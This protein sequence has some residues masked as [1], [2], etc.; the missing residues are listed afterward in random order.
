M[1]IK[2]SIFKRIISGKEYY[3]YQYLEDGKQVSKTISKLEAYDIA[4]SL[5]FKGRDVDEFKSHNFNLQVQYG[6][7]LISMTKVYDLYKRRYCYQDVSKYINSERTGGKV[8]ILYG[9][10]RTGKTTLIFQSISD[11][12][13]KD[14]AK[15][16]YIKCENGKTMYQLFEDL[17]YLTMNGF[18]Y[19]YIDEVTLLE[20]FISLSSTLSDIYA[21]K[22]KVILS[23]TDSLGFLIA[24]HH[25]LYDRYKM[26]H[27][28]YISYKE[29]QDVLGIKSID[30]YIEFGGTM[31]MEGIDYN[32]VIQ[33]GEYY[34]N[35]YVDSSIVHNIIH[36]LKLYKDGSYF[37]HLYDL[38]QKGELVNVINRIIEDT[39][40]RFA[41]SV[42]ERDFK[43]YD[44]G[45]LKQLLSLPN[46][47]MKFGNV[48][49]DVDEQKL[50]SDLMKALQIINIE[51][52]SHKIDDD[53]LK[54]VEYYLNRLELSY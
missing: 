45:S 9:L 4:F 48:L 30:K 38:Y 5:Y 28:T 27:T 43:S 36:S 18:E 22:A 13:I 31:T 15:A 11:L 51:K 42:I 21:M 52:Q 37:F 24:G 6:A 20:E 19:L 16:A 41:V 49:K 17:K 32:N 3:Y 47:Y 46:N 50:V 35:E 23:G 25:E 34:I 40:H 29:F 39:N 1:K 12:S 10:R 54:E 14:F 33:N 2:G 8:L 53:V 7:S 44:Y 26:V